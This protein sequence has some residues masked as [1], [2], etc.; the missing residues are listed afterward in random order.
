MNA[1]RQQLQRLKDALPGQYVTIQ[2]QHAIH[3]DGT[4]ATEFEAYAAKH[5]RML[6]LSIKDAVDRLIAKANGTI[7][8]QDAAE[9]IDQI[10][11]EQPAS[12]V[13]L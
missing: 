3:E 4:E 8:P 12:E 11:A 1:A 2:A 9:A 10:G 5:G 6:G 7:E 13:T